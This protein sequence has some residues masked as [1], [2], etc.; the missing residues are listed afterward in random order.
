MRYYNDTL[1]ETRK[2]NALSRDVALLRKEG[3]SIRNKP[4]PCTIPGRFVTPNPI[5]AILAEMVVL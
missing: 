5:R 1:E 3:S 2:M 4:S